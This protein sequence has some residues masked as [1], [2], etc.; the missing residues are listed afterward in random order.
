MS[1]VNA[2][3]LDDYNERIRI[4]AHHTPGGRLTDRERLRIAGSVARQHGCTA[5][6]LLRWAEEADA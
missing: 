3:A 2:N 4:S 1:T 6:D 5:V